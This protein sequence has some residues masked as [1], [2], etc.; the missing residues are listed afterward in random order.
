MLRGRPILPLKFEHCSVFRTA[1]DEWYELLARHGL[2]LQLDVNRLMT[3][4]FRMMASDCPCCKSKMRT[5]HDSGRDGWDDR[6]IAYVACS[7]CGFWRCVSEHD[8]E[9]T[10]TIPYV[11]DFTD[12]QNIASLAPLAQIIARQPD[13]LLT[14]NPKQLEVFVGSILRE[15]MA[16]DVYHVGGTGDD[17]VDLLAIVKDEPLV[18]QVKRRSRQ[19]AVEGIDVV[20]L[21]FASGMGQGIR[22]GMVV[23]TAQRFSRAALTWTNLSTL[24]EL[25]F[26]FRL[27]DLQSFLSMIRAVRH[28]GPEPWEQHAATRLRNLE[29]SMMS[30][31]SQRLNDGLIV[32][33]DIFGEGTYAVF[34][35]QAIGSC[36]EIRIE[37]DFLKFEWEHLQDVDGVLQAAVRL[38]ATVTSRAGGALASLMNTYPAALIADVGRVW[39]S[40]DARI[41]I[42][43]HP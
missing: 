9:T 2:E 29:P 21:L 4:R 10:V 39:A 28:D 43:Q 22:N 18:V 19:N 11:S 37:N 16:C 24:H 20:K 6:R 5:V 42:R 36:V 34:A 23:S 26:R 30:W 17:G 14:M 15:H 25:K 27:V 35:D 32:R 38:G 7:A 40:H 3:L 31:S 33:H 13:R 41:R 1:G 8:E 12:G